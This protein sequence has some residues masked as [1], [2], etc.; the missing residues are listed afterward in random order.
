MANKWYYCDEDGNKQGPF[1]SAELKQLARV[2]AVWPST[3]IETGDGRTSVASKIKGLF[4]EPPPILATTDNMPVPVAVPLPPSTETPAKGKTVSQA[5]IG[6]V[7]C[8]VLVPCL[9]LAT[10]FRS[11]ESP[12]PEHVDVAQVEQV[13]IPIAEWDIEIKNQ[14]IEK[15]KIEQWKMRRELM[16]LGQIPPDEDYIAF[17][18]ARKKS[19]ESMVRAGLPTDGI[20]YEQ[21]LDRLASIP[22][23]ARNWS[24]HNFSKV[25]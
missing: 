25:V 11:H 5:V 4:P 22:K 24:F 10:F 23:T 21:F 3:Q 6:G 9:L 1:T 13:D 16:A 14:E 12:A 17:L 20:E 2:G 8:G 18:H 19:R 7:A 15:L